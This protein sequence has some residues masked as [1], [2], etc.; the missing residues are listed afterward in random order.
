MVMWGRTKEVNERYVANYNA[1]YD[2]NVG[3][4]SAEFMAPESAPS[5]FETTTG[6]AT[7]FNPNV[8]GGMPDQ[9]RLGQIPV[10]QQPTVDQRNFYHQMDADEARRHSIE[11]I[12]IGFKE[13]P[14]STYRRTDSPY[15]QIWSD[16]PRPMT[17][18]KNPNT[19]SETR[20]F[21]QASYQK[22]LGAR[23]L[24]GNHFSMAG[25][26]RNYE[27]YGMK[28]PSHSRNTYR[29]SPTPW[30]SNIVDAPENTPEYETD[31]NRASRNG[32]RSYRLG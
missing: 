8:P 31:V 26:R 7:R 1:D 22:G 27:I 20:P 10:Y 2:S 21:D 16:T 17:S 12:D 3:Q 30:D 19:W 29:L 32:T 5:G 15:Q 13:E 25:H 11:K 23:F 4:P 9:M 24:N 6:Y 14:R 28:P 18:G